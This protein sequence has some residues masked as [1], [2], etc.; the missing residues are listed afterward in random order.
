M[1][2]ASEE[3]TV[4]RAPLPSKWRTL[5]AGAAT[6]AVVLAVAYAIIVTYQDRRWSA[7]AQQQAQD[8]VYASPVLSR[9]IG[10]VTA[11]HDTS[12]MHAKRTPPTYDV[13][14]HVTGQKGDGRVEV[15]L[16]RR[17]PSEWMVS[18]AKLERDGHQS[19]SLF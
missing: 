9:N 10:A 11:V 7:A 3:P 5:V 1:E 4:T 15:V 2:T 17:G 12:E 19:V 14:F 8:F 16:T 13:D 6:C 18:S